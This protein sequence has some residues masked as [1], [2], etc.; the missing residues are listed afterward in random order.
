V[1]RVGGDVQIWSSPGSG[2]SVMMTV[3]YV[4]L[5]GPVRSG[6]HDDDGTLS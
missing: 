2:T 3:P 1:G 6:I 5:A 4:A